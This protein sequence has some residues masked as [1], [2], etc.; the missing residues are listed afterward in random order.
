M[1]NKV[2]FPKYDNNLWSRIRQKATFEELKYFTLQLFISCY[3][4]WIQYALRQSKVNS[5]R[6]PNS[7]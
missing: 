4:V 3:S 7:K 1:V 2:I 6:V 5:G